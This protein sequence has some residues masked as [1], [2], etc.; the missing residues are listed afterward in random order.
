VKSRLG[1][2]GVDTNDLRYN[3]RP[4]D[5]ESPFLVGEGMLEI[6]IFGRSPIVDG[7]DYRETRS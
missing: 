3:L 5:F 4:F 2:F 7:I 1:C 6:L